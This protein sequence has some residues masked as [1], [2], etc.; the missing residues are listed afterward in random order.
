[1]LTL[2]KKMF[3]TKMATKYEKRIDIIKDALEGRSV[4]SLSWV[5]SE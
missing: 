4:E 5:G 2:I 1:M 3:N